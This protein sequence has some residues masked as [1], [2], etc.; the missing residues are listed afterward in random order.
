MGDAKSA[1]VTRS[2]AAYD[3]RLEEP[4]GRYATGAKTARRVH[5]FGPRCDLE[6]HFAP[7]STHEY[8]YD[9]GPID[10]RPPSAQE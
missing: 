10:R 2:A 1:T 3:A 7:A 9:A 5:F 8:R 4:W 6:V